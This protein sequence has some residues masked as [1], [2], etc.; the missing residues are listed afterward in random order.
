MREGADV[1]PSELSFRLD[2]GV[3]MVTG[4]ASGIGSAIATALAEMGSH[5]AVV[6]LPSSDASATLE[7]IRAAGRNAEFIPADVTKPE[8]MQAAVER[9]ESSLGPLTAAVNSAGIAHAV[10]AE[11]MTLEQF[12]RVFQINVTGVFL[13]CQAQARA[14]KR[15]GGGAIV[16]LASISGI[17]SHREMLQSHYNSSKAAVAHLSKSLATEWAPY[18]IRVNSISPGFT[19]TPMNDRAEVASILDEAVTRN[20]PLGR[21][22]EPLEMA[23]PAVFLLSSAA[24]FCTGADLVVDGGFTAW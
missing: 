1:N 24:S 21:P 13:S 8:Q 4:G 18:G 12:E 16:N 20:T 6:D 22:A 23:G 14:M 19:R 9:V 7:A 15:N 2:G 17:V 10:A 3:T 5:V 11:D